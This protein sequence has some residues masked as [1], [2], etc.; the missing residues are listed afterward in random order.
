MTSLPSR[1]RPPL[2]A[3][4]SARDLPRLTTVFAQDATRVFPKLESI[5][6]GALGIKRPRDNDGVVI[7]L[8]LEFL[9]RRD[10]AIGLQEEATISMHARNPIC[11]AA[12]ISS[13][14]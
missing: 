9:S 8:G 10:A 11:R 2:A 4:I 13:K 7:R 1:S 5:P 12:V 14:A 3:P 6:R